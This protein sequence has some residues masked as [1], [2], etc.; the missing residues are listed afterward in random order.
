[1][2][3]IDPVCVIHGKKVSEHACLYCCM[4]FVSLTPEECSTNAAGIKED[5]CMP[6]ALNERL[7]GKV[8][9]KK[10]VLLQDFVPVA[11]QYSRPATPRE[12]KREGKKLLAQWVWEHWGD[13]ESV[14]IGAGRKRERTWTMWKR[15]G[16]ALSINR[17]GLAKLHP[18]IEFLSRLDSCTLLKCV[19]YLNRNRNAIK[20]KA[21]HNTK[22]K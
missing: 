12:R 7:V 3:E 21:G 17:Y 5:V 8:L 14:M 22:S 9:K 4:C 10:P 16:E 18:S 2:T 15:S 20:A 11:L 1:M 13:G 6:C 19:K